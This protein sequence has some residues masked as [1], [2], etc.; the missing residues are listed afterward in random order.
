MLTGT[1]NPMVLRLRG[2]YDGAATGCQTKTMLLFA[3]S[4]SSPERH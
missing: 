2:G 1:M 4:S 3:F